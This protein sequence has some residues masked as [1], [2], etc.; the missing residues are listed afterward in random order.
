MD[1]EPQGR[2][3]VYDKSQERKSQKPPLPLLCPVSSSTKR[4]E[5]GTGT[6]GLCKGRQHCS[7]EGSPCHMGAEKSDFLVLREA[8]AGGLNSS[9]GPGPQKLGEE[10]LPRVVQGW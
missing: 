6:P 5:L 4:P 7:Q 8:R 3:R 10:A 2:K 9:E 1:L